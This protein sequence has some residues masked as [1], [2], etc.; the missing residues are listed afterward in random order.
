MRTVIF[1]KCELVHVANSVYDERSIPN[2]LHFVRNGLKEIFLAKEFAGSESDSIASFENG[3]FVSG[4]LG[5]IMKE[6]DSCFDE[7][8]RS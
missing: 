7:S 4:V 1:I 5:K 6:N 3:I 2:G 8:F